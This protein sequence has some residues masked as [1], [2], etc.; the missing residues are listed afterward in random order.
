VGQTK[1]N[2]RGAEGQDSALARFAI[3]LVMARVDLQAEINDTFGKSSALAAPAFDNFDRE[4]RE[5]LRSL[6]K[7][8]RFL[9]ALTS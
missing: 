6:Q 7:E 9:K 5:L 1:N 3:L 2:D 8:L 4:A